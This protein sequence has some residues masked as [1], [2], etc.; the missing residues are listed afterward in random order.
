MWV[1][2]TQNKMLLKTMAKCWRILGKSYG[3]LPNLTH[4]YEN[5]RC[6]SGFVA[7]IGICIR[8]SGSKA[9]ESWSHSE[10]GRD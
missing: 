1:S 2:L 3:R 5:C 4:A 7:L 8:P 9:Y 10:A 6:A